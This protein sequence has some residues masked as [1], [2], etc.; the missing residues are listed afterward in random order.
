MSRFLLA[1]IRL[2]TPDAEREWVVGDTLE[3]FRHR[4]QTRGRSSAW[5]WLFR[6]FF[7]VLGAAPAHRLAVRAVIRE[8][9][10]LRLRR[11]SEALAQDTR[12]F[13]RRS[14]HARA[15]TLT[16]VSVQLIA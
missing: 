9:R 8:P 16:A 14:F 10:T 12:F 7:R 13:F 5:R 1:L 3:E 6:E 15:F 2:L 4:Q 11:Y